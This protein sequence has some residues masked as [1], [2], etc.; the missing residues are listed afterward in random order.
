MSLPP[1]WLLHPPYL[2]LLKTPAPIETGLNTP[3]LKQSLKPRSDILSFRVHLPKPAA[4]PAP[5]FP[6]GFS[7]QQWPEDMS[8]SSHP[9]VG[10]AWQVSL[11]PVSKVRSVW[12][13]VLL[14]P[15]PL[16]SCRIL[17]ALLDPLGKIVPLLLSLCWDL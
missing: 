16:G 17:S 15:L 7:Y 13:W 6:M 4:D 5:C 11:S 3:S 8:M 14:L 9:Y 1:G 2:S 10:L 12:E